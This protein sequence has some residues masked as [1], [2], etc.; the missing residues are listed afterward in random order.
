MAKV[1][2]HLRIEERNSL[3]D[4][5]VLGIGQVSD[6]GALRFGSAADSVGPHWWHSIGGGHYFCSAPGWVWK[7][8]RPARG[9]HPRTDARNPPG[10]SDP[11]DISY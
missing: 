9:N 2:S 3:S 7:I 1:H 8:T 5:A 10:T 4:Q 11:P 6:D